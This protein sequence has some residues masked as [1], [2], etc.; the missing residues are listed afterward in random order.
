M[1]MPPKWLRLGWANAGV[2][3]SMVVLVYPPNWGIWGVKRGLCHVHHR[4]AGTER[5]LS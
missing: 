2:S 5:G 1:G 4:P 3:L